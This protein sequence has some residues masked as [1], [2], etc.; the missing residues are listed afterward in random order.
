MSAKEHK[1]KS[2]KERKRVLLC[3]KLQPARFETTR[4]GNSQERSGRFLLIFWATSQWPHSGSHFKVFQR[5][6]DDNK[7]IICGFERGGG[8]GIAGREENRPKRF[9]S[10]ETPRQ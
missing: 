4:L 1:R 5:R 6:R 8:G 9:F 3:V 7:N 2:A 10:G